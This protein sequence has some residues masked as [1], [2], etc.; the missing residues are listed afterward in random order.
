LFL[1]VLKCNG[2]HTLRNV[3]CADIIFFLFVPPE[4][5][6]Q[7]VSCWIPKQNQTA[8][9]FFLFCQYINC[10][11]IIISCIK[12]A[13]LPVHSQTKPSILFSCSVSTLLFCF[14]HLLSSGVAWIGYVCVHQFLIFFFID[15]LWTSYSSRLL[16]I[17]L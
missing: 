14:L 3:C 12:S 1:K 10:T 7:T 11:Y 9:R 8:S 15:W 2:K 5:C 13:Y 4:L 6:L 17:D 16:V